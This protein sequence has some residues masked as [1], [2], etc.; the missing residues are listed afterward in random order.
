MSF[1]TLSICFL[2]GSLAL[3]LL[4]VR[5]RRIRLRA[6]L[7]ALGVSVAILFGL[8]AVFD[9]L[10]IYSGLFDYESETLLGVHLGL[11]PIE[12]FTYPLAAVLFVPAL[13]W[14]CGGL[15]PILEE[16]E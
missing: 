13:W 1:A 14:L 15:P 3:F 10:M 2:L 7:P 8:T 6:V 5:L 16:Q 11:A 12:D 9:N 4:A